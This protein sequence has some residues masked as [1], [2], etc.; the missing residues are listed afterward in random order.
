MNP[1]EL[2]EAAVD[3][4][5]LQAAECWHGHRLG[6]F[7][8]PVLC[9]SAPY[10]GYHVEALLRLQPNAAPTMLDTTELIHRL[11]ARGSTSGLDNWVISSSLDFLARHS[12]ALNGL[13]TLSV[14][15]SPCSLNN[16]DF[17]DDTLALFRAYPEQSAKL[18]LEITEVS[19][20]SNF[21]SIQRFLAQ[22]RTLGVK[23]ALDDF[24]SGYS[25]FRY[26][27]DLQFDIIKIDGSIVRTIC[28]NR[29]S[30]AVVSSIAKL[31]RD[32]NCTS[33]AEWVEDTDTL[34]AL[35]A[36]DIHG[37]QGKLV[38]MAMEPARFLN[39]RNLNCVLPKGH[40]DGLLL[41]PDSRLWA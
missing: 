26:V 40:L 27:I 5:H 11:E 36:L 4:Q 33:V 38:A 10:E 14:N 17:L 7:W 37:F 30:R 34:Q 6:L 35:L 39:A 31:A 16:D 13:R 12:D 15:V 1:F 25:N 3:Y 29:A 18:C 21:R 19:R 32:L 2:H 23:V 20:L 24:G 9:R 8:Q 22:S 41:N 28:H